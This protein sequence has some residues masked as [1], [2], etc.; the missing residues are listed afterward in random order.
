MTHR[1]R[2]GVAVAAAGALVAAGLVAA[3]P[4]SPAATTQTA[5]CTDGGGHVWSGQSTWGDVF[6]D[7]ATGETRRQNDDT[8]MKSTAAD[9]TT[10]DYT[11]KTYQPDGSFYQTL[12]VVDGAYTPGNWIIRNP[13]NPRTNRGKTKIVVN[14][15]DGNDGYGNCTMTFVEPPAETTPLASTE[16]AVVNGWGTPTAGDE[17]SYTGAPDPAKWSVYSGSGHSS[18]GTRDPARWS[19][20]GSYAQVDGLDTGSGGGM[21]SKFDRDGSPGEV[22]GA[23]SSGR[24]ETRMRVYGATT[25][26]YRAAG[27]HPVLIVWPDAGRNCSTKQQE[28]DYSESTSDVTLARTFIH[29]APTGTCTDSTKS[30]QRAVDMRQWHNYAVEWTQE[31]LTTYIDGQVLFSTTDPEVIPDFASHSTIQLDNFLGDLSETHMDI[32]WTRYYALSGEPGGQP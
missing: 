31:K 27:W 4:P 21:S 23:T 14:I 16:A 15:G 18:N 30:A 10:V 25:A 17:F 3:Q 22:V 32:D 20:N 6:V 19:V 9:A 13:A 11:V 8:R 5:T 29:Y 12:K 2:S 24:W 1:I 26:S 7:A 28:I